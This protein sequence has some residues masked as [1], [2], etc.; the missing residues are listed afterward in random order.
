MEP[1]FS[2]FKLYFIKMLFKNDCEWHVY[3]LPFSDY[4]RIR[5]G[6]ARENEL[7]DFSDA[8]IQFVAYGEL[9]VLFRKSALQA[10]HFLWEPMKG[11]VDDDEPE[12]HESIRI[13]MDS[14]LIPVEAGVDELEPVFSFYNELSACEDSDTEF[15]GFPDE[16]GEEIFINPKHANLIEIP[17][18][19]LKDT[20]DE[21]ED[22][23]LDDTED[24]G[25]N[26]F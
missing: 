10:V 1:D 9:R 24:K 16:D 13:F 18:Y 4:G 8:F 7:M 14:Q 12:E 11:R 6:F 22:D 20:D 25:E 19:M 15:I 2:E 21:I 17:E 23:T 26:V 3:R 5:D